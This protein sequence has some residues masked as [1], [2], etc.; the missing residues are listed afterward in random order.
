MHKKILAALVL[1]A[2]GVVH[3]QQE[4]KDTLSIKALRMEKFDERHLGTLLLQIKVGKAVIVE[5]EA[6]PNYEFNAEE[7]KK[8]YALFVRNYLLDLNPFSIPSGIEADTKELKV[9]AAPGEFEP[10]VFGVYPAA[11]LVNCRTEFSDFVN[12]NGKK[13][14]PETF[15][16]NDVKYRPIGDDIV[17]VRSEVLERSNQISRI[18]K[19]IAKQIWINIKVPEDS[20]PGTYRGI[21]MFEP[22][23][24]PASEIKAEVKVLPF[25]LMQPPPEVMNWAPMMSGTWDFER[26]EQE[27]KCIK[28]HGMTGE[29]TSSLNPVGED[30][31]NAN[32]YMELAKKAGLPGKFIMST[33]GTQ[34]Y[35]TIANC[36][37]PFG[38]GEK[39]F[40]EEAYTKLKAG[41]AKVKAN[42]EQNKWLP[43]TMYLSSELG[44]IIVPGD[45]YDR[46]MKYAEEYYTAARSVSGIKLLATFNKQD[47]LKRHWNLPTLDEFGFNGEMFPAW[48][49]A[50][51]MK[52]SWM[53]FIA[54]DQRFGYGF[55]LWRFNFKGGRPWCLNP[56]VMFPREAGL[57]Y[58]FNKIA[59]PSV[60]FE[61]IRE[62]VD[63]YKYV[64]TLLEHIKKAKADGKD[65][66]AA[67][68]TLKKI[69][70]KL[71]YN[72]KTDTPG[73]DYLKMDS[74]RSQIAEEIEH[75]LK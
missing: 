42:A 48:E 57:V 26:L 62:G 24:R 9:F 22:E 39:N 44:G 41:L 38:M 72:H 1:V 74:Y 43:Y 11:D 14:A 29:I 35:G 21:I 60:R 36:A 65:A 16:I 63:D 20:P 7:N 58:Y 37:G 61:R 47:E 71:P 31:T 75:L 25:K 4:A 73:F 45:E 32:R 55:Y 68:N 19:G 23:G 70:L 56:G 27:F 10:L 54:V 30:F 46:M 3:A 2:F 17:T 18:D 6:N 52:P 59:H 13:L 67:E 66:S 53:T 34:G 8:G 40:C 49:E 12:E 33:Y 5:K 28:E 51:K 69:F 50:A 15:Q 64:Y